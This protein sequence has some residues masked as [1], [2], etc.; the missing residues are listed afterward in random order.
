MVDTITRA[1]YEHRQYLGSAGPADA[2][3]ADLIAQWQQA[4]P[5]WAGQYWAFQ[6][7]TATDREP[8]PQRPQHLWL[9]PVNVSARRKEAP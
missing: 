5:D 1:E 3:A 7:D 8:D 4:H 2:L 6:P 9:R